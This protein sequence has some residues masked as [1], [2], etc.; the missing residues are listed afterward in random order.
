MVLTK[1]DLLGPQDDPPALDAPEA[2]GVFAVSSV[3][4]RGLS[5]LLEALWVK[6]REVIDEE[7]TGTGDEDWDTP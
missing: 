1:I 3:A 7:A 4:R 5:D 6:L 2:W